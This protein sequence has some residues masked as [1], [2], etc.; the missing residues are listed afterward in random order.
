MYYSFTVKACPINLFTCAATL[1]CIQMAF[2][3]DGSNDCS[4]ASDENKCVQGNF[5]V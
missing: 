5:E 1:E 2:R 4:D 3:C